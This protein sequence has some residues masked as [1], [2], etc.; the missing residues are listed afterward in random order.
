MNPT[1][2]SLICACGIA[3]LFYLDRDKFARTSK[4]LWIPVIWIWIVGSRPVS[5]WLGMTPGGNVQLEGSPLDAAIFGIL[6]L[7]AVVVLVRRGTQATRLLKANWAILAY[8]LYCLVAISWSYH[9]DVSLKRWIKAIGDLAMVLVIATDAKPVDALKRLFSRVGFLLF[10]ASILIIKYYPYLGQ[11]YTPDGVQSN[12]GVTTNKNSLGVILLIISLGTVWRILSL[13]RATNQPDRR[14]HLISQA[15]L[16]A[17]ELSLLEMAD[18]KTCISC[19]LLGAGLIIATNSGVIRRRP[20][21]VHALC[22]A[23]L[24]AGGGGLLFGGEAGVVQALGRKSNFSGRTDIW[25][26]VIAAAPNPVVGAGFE[27]FWIGPGAPKVWGRLTSEGWWNAEGINEAHDGYIE[28]Y[29]NLGW[30]G[31]V[32][33]V[34]ILINGYWHAVR[35]FQ[36]NSQLGSLMLAYVMCSAVYSITEAGFRMLDPIWIFLLLAAVFAPVVSEP[37][38]NVY[39]APVDWK[40]ARLGASRESFSRKLRMIARSE[41]SRHSK[42]RTASTR[43]NDSDTQF[44]VVPVSPGIS[45]SAFIHL[46]HVFIHK[47]I[48]P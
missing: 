44:D 5:D 34:L 27:S 30:I 37:T 3:G 40:S 29:L 10:P 2:A 4:A 9:P 26:A 35:A 45:S 24:L 46:D 23:I 14:R 42:L 1:L 16:L 31:V 8:F 43:S 13:L 6:L 41:P 21:R 22:L 39:D 47:P 17:F 36:R 25:A 38:D 19:F 11:E 28:V 33:I 18:C 20:A 32:L 7:S 15:V 12:T 48:T